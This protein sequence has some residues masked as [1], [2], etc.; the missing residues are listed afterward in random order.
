[1]RFVMNL[2]D[3][4]DS[5][6]PIFDNLTN[7]LSF[8]LDNRSTKRTFSAVMEQGGTSTLYTWTSVVGSDLTYTPGQ[9][10][11]IVFTI[12]HNQA[13]DDYGAAQARYRVWVNGVMIRDLYATPAGTGFINTGAQRLFSATDVYA[14]GI[15]SA[16]IWYNIYQPDGDVSGLGTADVVIDGNETLWN[17]TGLPSGWAKAGAGVFT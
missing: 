17:G 14:M 15:R 8:K 2:S 9:R 1:M 13:I 11:E 4:T 5:A 10:T 7:N 16:Q 6:T 12:T 3:D